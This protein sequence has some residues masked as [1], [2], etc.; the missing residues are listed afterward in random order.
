MVPAALFALGFVEL[1]TMRTDGWLAA[2]GVELV[3]AVVLTFRRPWPAIVAPLTVAVLALIPLTG[4]RME[5]AAAPLF[6]DF[7]TPFV[8]GRV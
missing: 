3:A 1:I 5:D 4:T 8:Y 7:V 2:A 6:R